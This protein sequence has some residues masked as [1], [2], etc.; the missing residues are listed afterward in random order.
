MAEPLTESGH[1]YLCV[2]CLNNRFLQIEFPNAVARDQWSRIF[3]ATDGRNPNR[4]F[5]EAGE[6]GGAGSGRGKR[7]RKLSN[8]TITTSASDPL[9][10]TVM[11][12][13]PVQVHPSITAIITPEV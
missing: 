4:R 5:Q 8:D 10:M 7:R 13:G 11:V 9:P 12:Q 6:A 1:Y 2:S 3:N